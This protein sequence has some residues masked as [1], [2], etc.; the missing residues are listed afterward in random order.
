VIWPLLASVPTEDVRA[1]LTVARRRSFRRGE[2]VFHRG[3]PADSLHLV[4]QGRFAVYVTTP[5][6]DTVIFDLLGRGEVFGELAV[7]L[8]DRR[9]P[10]TVEAIEAGETRSIYRDDFA[11][12]QERHPGVQ[13]V[14]LG[15]V[16][17]QVQ[18]LSQ[19]LVEAHFVDAERRLRRR[20]VELA[21][22]H[23]PG[24]ALVAL[25]QEQLAALAG[26]SRATANRVLRQEAERG[27][28]ALSRGQMRVLDV[29][30]LRQRSR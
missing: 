22:R 11:A 18:R 2:V 3:D 14:L 10:A 24:G 26:T 7:L 25:T 21:E 23:A 13:E 19:R 28:V 27:A 12:L 1:L 20:L 5:L 6:G 8:P 4:V 29:H 15:L 30:G 16:A 17:D 9:R